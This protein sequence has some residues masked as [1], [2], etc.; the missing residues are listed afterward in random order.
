MPRH[1]KF[2]VG[3]V[4]WVMKF[5]KSQTPDVQGNVFFPIVIVNFHKDCGWNICGNVGVQN[6]SGKKLW[7]CHRSHCLIGKAKCESKDK[8]S[9]QVSLIKVELYSFFL[10]HQSLRNEAGKCM[11]I[12]QE[13]KPKSTRWKCAKN[14]RKS[15]KSNLVFFK[16]ERGKI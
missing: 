14:N 8:H 5:K 1:R 4:Y 6:R 2:A 12:M 16:E 9:Y 13:Y 3:R 7:D 11:H 10:N 15:I